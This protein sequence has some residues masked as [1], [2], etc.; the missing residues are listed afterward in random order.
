M[1]TISVQVVAVAN[2]DFFFCL[3]SLFLKSLNCL[4][5]D[6]IV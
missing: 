4:H 3:V 6:Y 1:L 2:T 5:I